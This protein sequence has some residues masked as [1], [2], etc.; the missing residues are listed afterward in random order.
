MHV[1]QTPEYATSVFDPIGAHISTTIKDKIYAG[2][3][4]DLPSND[5]A[6]DP[7]LNGN[8]SINGGQLTVVQ[9]KQTPLTNIHVWTWHS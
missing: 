1:R 5:L 4:T 3:Y 2:E 8:I 7:H 9:Q 6:T